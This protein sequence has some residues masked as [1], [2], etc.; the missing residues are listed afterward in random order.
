M[1]YAQARR[2]GLTLGTGNVEA[3][4]KSLFETSDAAHD[5]RRRP[6]ST[7]YSYEPSP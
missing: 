7:S 3:T 1:N 4:C 2:L 5:R 6:V